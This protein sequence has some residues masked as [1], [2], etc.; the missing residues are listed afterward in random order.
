MEKFLVGGAVRDSIMGIK[1]NDWDFSVVAP[2]F[3]AMRAELITEGFQIFVETPE[4]FTIRARGPKGFTFGGM[5]FGTQ[6]FDF[7]W[8]R[9]DGPYSDGRR[10]DFVEPGTLLDDISRRDFS[11]NAIAKDSA[12]MLIDPFGG[13]ED[14][15]RKV[16]RAVGDARQRIVVEDALRGMR[17]IRFSVTKGFAIHWNVIDV[18]RSDEFRLALRSISTERIQGELDKAFKVDTALTIKMLTDLRLV[19]TIFG[20]DRLRLMTTTKD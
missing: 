9:K 12:G 3:E 5:D 6:T 2:S 14:I 17:A 1:S 8:A 18:L 10:P 19:D 7:V 20:R 4:F 16:I 11:C 15:K 13:Q